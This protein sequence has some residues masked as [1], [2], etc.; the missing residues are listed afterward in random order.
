MLIAQLKDGQVIDIADYRSVFP[1]TSFPASGPSDI[2]MIENNCM[3]V[4]LFLPYDQ[5]TQC[6]ESVPPYIQIDDPEQRLNWVYT[7]VVAELTPE[8][9]EQRNENMRAAN[10][11]QATLLLQQT[12]WTTIPDVSDPAVSDPY[13]VNS[14]EFATYRNQVRK[15]AVNPPVIVDAWPVKPEEVWQI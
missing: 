7:V 12:D 8:Q 4:N 3:Y 5:S 10:K 9:I 13:L 6:L 1:D 15:I 11:S 2:F 14:A